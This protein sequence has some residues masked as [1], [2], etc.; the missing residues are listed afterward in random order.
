MNAEAGHSSASTKTT[1]VEPPGTPPGA[2]I[3]P[4]LAVPGDPTTTCAFPAPANHCFHT[5]P[6]APVHLAHQE[7]FCLTPRHTACPLFSQS[8]EPLAD[9]EL[10]REL[11]AA[12]I[13]DLGPE[14]KRRLGQQAAIG[15]AV[16]L[17]T[18]LFLAG[19]SNRDLLAARW[20]GSAQTPPS[21]A[22]AT[23]APTPMGIVSGKQATAAATATGPATEMPPPTE[24]V[25][26]A[27]TE[28]R[29]TA[30]TVPSAPAIANETRIPATTATE[31]AAATATVPPTPTPTATEEVVACIPRSD[32]NAVHVVQP[33]ETLYRISLRYGIPLAVFQEANCLEGTTVYAGQQLLAPFQLPPATSVPATATPASTNTAPPPPPPTSE[34]PPAPPATNTPPPPTATAVPPTA[35]MPAPTPTAPL[36]VPQETQLPTPTLPS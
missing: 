15:A 17:V 25:P 33:G 18:L 30:T 11:A 31:A 23:M 21:R 8:A 26:P 9:P 4:Y 28:R 2:S 22:V 20:F 12:S 36:P 6:T 35:T 1:Q 19:W 3:C 14:R 7:Q 29:V 34:P 24:T 27:A 16:L 32:W 5:Q 13:L 10:R